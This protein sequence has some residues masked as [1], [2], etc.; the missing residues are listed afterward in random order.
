MLSDGNQSVRSNKDKPYICKTR[1][2][3]EDIIQSTDSTN[4]NPLEQSFYDDA[5]YAQDDIE[6]YNITEDVIYNVRLPKC[7]HTATETPTTI[8]TAKT[9]DAVKSHKVQRILLDSG[10]CKTL[11]KCP[12]L[13][14][15][16]K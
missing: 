4:Y 7:K 1:I 15:G 9:I 6:I 16:N 13:Q 12:A 5:T 8:C 3:E 2:Y 11:I 10:S 14:R